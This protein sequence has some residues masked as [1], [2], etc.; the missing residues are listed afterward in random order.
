MDPVKALGKLGMLGNTLNH[1]D[2][3]VE[4]LDDLNDHWTAKNHKH[5]RRII[6]EDLQDF[7]A[8]RSVRV[9]ILSGDVHLAAVGQF[10][11]NP[12]HGLA[13][14]NDF[15]YMPNVISSAIVNTPPPDL[16]ADVLNKRNKIHHFDKDTEENMIPMFQH[17]VE[18]KPRNNKHLLPHRNWCSIRAWSPGGT[19][20]PTPPLSAY[21]RSPSP[22]GNRGGGGILRRLSKTRGPTYRPDAPREPRESREPQEP[23]EPREP[24]ER[25]SRPP[26]SGGLFRAFS[27][28]NS[29]DSERPPKPRRTLSLTRSDF[30]PRNLF[31]R[32]GSAR[33]RYADD[34][35][36]NGEWGYDSQE[37]DYYDESPD[38]RD[39]RD[40]VTRAAP[41]SRGRDQGNEMRL[42][43]GG[44]HDE[45]A[46]GDE[47][48]FTSRPVRRAH[49]AVEE[50][51]PATSDESPPVPK[52]FH[53]T[54][55]GLSVKQLKKSDAY[56]VNLEGGL[57]ICINVEVNPKDPAGIT[58]P[59]RLLVPRLFYEYQGEDSMVHQ[60][61]GF[62]RLI[63]F[64]KRK[65]NYLPSPEDED[66][67]D[68]YLHP[69]PPARQQHP[70][71]HQQ[72]HPQ[73]HSQQH[74]QHPQHPQQRE[75]RI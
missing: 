1:I 17:G 35:G 44:K 26:V 58:L 23:R 6:I 55:T 45:Y 29:G 49:T 51:R 71:Q 36:I 38:M 3:G 25:D 73:Q 34:G 20:P 53:R 52:P 10:F 28:R 59:Y 61:S 72:Q 40:P 41:G 62:K 13:K 57:D 43:G 66:P 22:P 65:P 69:T 27:R 9:T 48:Y 2:G 63:S 30:N 33:G 39:T 14:H 7:A 74:P 21:D 67:D 70:Q 31:G 75:A 42:R 54:P 47:E 64:R 8:E 19:P 12:K 15:R 68:G 60:P 50:K 37:G 5:E 4:V 46:E 16:L 32:R 18:G 11:S 56:E 24:R